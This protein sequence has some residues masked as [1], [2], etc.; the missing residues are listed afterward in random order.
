MCPSF[1]PPYRAGDAADVGQALFP[2]WLCVPCRGL[3]DVLGRDGVYRHRLVRVLGS[4]RL[5]GTTAR[6]AGKLPQDPEIGEKRS[7]RSDCKAG[8]ASLAE[9]YGAGAEATRDLDPEHRPGAVAAGGWA[10]PMRAWRSLFRRAV[11][12]RCFLYALP[13]CRDR[14]TR[15][16]AL[17]GQNGERVWN[18]GRAAAKRAFMQCI[19][20]L[21]RRF[22]RERRPGVVRDKFEAQC[23]EAAS[24][25]VAWGRPRVRRTSSL[26][27]R[28]I[29]GPDRFLFARQLIHRPPEPAAWALRA[30][31]LPRNF[32]QCCPQ[33]T[34]GGPGRSRVALQLDGYRHR[35]NRL[36]NLRFVSPM[37]GYRTQPRE[38]RQLP[39]G[40][41]AHWRPQ[42]L[43][44]RGQDE[45]LGR[46]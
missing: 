6:N 18:V 28:L 13:G 30:W 1:A 25:A 10:T 17:L 29:P 36:K 22:R 33:A 26:I 15:H 43:G 41:P 39:R 5:V 38:R 42:V 35:D 31:A 2:H 12:I 8:A 44:D 23:A 19:R 40:Q 4:D 16:G 32:H 3:T 7:R 27:D 14:C 34:R 9:G 45:V 37:T 24:F 20:R 46:Q 11:L 21:R